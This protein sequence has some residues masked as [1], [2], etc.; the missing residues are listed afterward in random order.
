MTKETQAWGEVGK[1]RN[2][3][4]T[5]MP[6]FVTASLPLEK[7]GVGT[8]VSCILQDFSQK[9]SLTFIC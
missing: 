2:S 5:V 4:M 3:G 1:Q 6:N 7:E 8:F 9:T